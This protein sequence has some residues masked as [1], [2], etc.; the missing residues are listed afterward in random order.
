MVDDG[1]HYFNVSL[2]IDR[3]IYRRLEERVFR[4]N[5]INN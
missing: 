2:F 1:L 3:E 4:T 5:V